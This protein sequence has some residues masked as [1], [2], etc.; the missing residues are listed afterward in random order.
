MK[1]T[2]QE[3]RDTIIRPTLKYLDSESVGVENFLM[4]LAQMRQQQ[5]TDDNVCPLYPIDSAM[6][7]VV[8][9]QHL[10]YDPDRASLIRG[11]ASQR[12]FLVDPDTELTTNLAYATAIAWASYVA[13]PNSR[14]AVPGT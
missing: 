12:Q 8:W 9:D 4:A 13:Y 2:P 11:L 5:H 1:L 14:Q 3:L 6:H 10:A 7:R